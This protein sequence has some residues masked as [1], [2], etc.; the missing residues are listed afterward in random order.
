MKREIIQT[1]D[2]S[3]TI[4]LQEWNESY[5]SKHGAIQ[6]AQHVFI[7]NGLSLFREGP[8]SILEI[9][10]GT[11]LNAFI[12]FLEAPKLKLSIDYVGVEAYPVAPEELVLMNYVAELNAEDRK[13]VF[14]NIQKAS[15]CSYW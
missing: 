4:H 7:K 13:D 2:G 6:E 8:V 12:T 14:Q 3:T 11:G 15:L 9:G 1:L 10:F 5:H